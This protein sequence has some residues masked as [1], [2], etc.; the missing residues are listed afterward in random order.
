MPIRTD[1]DFQ[2]ISGVAEARENFTNCNRVEKWNGYYCN[3]ENLAMLTF[4][5]MDDDKTKRILSPIEIIAL[6][7]TSRNVLNTFMD[8]CWDE[9]Y[10]CLIRL[11][12]FPT[13]IEGGKNIFYQI[14]YTSTP[15]KK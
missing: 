12:R 7:T 10:T 1:R 11:S 13:L 8:H 5:S 15:P 14:I 3:N 4:E 2:L 6:N 9:F